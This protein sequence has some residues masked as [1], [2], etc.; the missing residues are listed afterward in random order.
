[1]NISAYSIPGLIIKTPVSVIDI[2]VCKVFSTSEDVLRKRTRE[3]KIVE[4]RQ[5][6]M[7]LYRKRTT[8][9]LH[10]IGEMLGNFD[11][12]TVVHAC[13]TVKNL[14]ETDKKFA[15]KFDMVKK[16]LTTIIP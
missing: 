15:Q 2:A 9:S 8:Y 5:T 13:R 10:E 16:E 6:A 1:M 3:R 14:I 11:H 12:T 7:Y 4:A